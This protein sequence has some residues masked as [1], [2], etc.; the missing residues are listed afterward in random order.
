MAE[1]DRDH[2]CYGTRLVGLLVLALPVQAVQRYSS[3]LC[4]PVAIEDRGSGLR[5]TR[6]TLLASGS[7]AMG[8]A[9]SNGWEPSP[10]NRGY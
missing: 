3:I 10:L 6:G 2:G 5:E 4:L 9:K 7:G 8:L 1:F